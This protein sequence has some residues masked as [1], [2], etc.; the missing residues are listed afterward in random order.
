VVEKWMGEDAEYEKTLIPCHWE[1][2]FLSLR[3]EGLRA[4]QITN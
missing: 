1:S 4:N 2:A 3:G